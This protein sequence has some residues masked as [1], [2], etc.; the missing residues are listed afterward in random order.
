MS[1]SGLSH[2]ELMDRLYRATSRSLAIFSVLGLTYFTAISAFGIMNSIA[3]RGHQSAHELIEQ[4]NH[5]TENQQS[6]S[7]DSNQ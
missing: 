6:K 7:T 3:G 1:M 2:K 5:F 4:E